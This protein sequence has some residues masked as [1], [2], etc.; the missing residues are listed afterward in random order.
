MD[1]T[2]NIFKLAHLFP[3]ALKKENFFFMLSL[4]GISRAFGGRDYSLSHNYEN[5]LKTWYLE[6]SEVRLIR[7]GDQLITEH[8]YQFE[9]P[10]RVQVDIPEHIP[11]EQAIEQ[12]MTMQPV[13]VNDGHVHFV[14]SSVPEPVSSPEPVLVEDGIAKEWPDVRADGAVLQLI[15][16]GDRLH[17]AII[18]P[19]AEP[20]EVPITLPDPDEMSIDEVINQLSRREC[21]LENDNVIRFKSEIDNETLIDSDNWSLTLVDSFVDRPW[22][23]PFTWGGHANIF[24]ETIEG[25]VPFLRW[26]HLM[27]SNYEPKIDERNLKQFDPSRIASQS[28]TWLRSKEMVQGM[29]DGIAYEKTRQDQGN[30]TANFNLRGNGAFGVKPK[31]VEGE[32]VTS[33]NCYTWAKDK[34]AKAGVHL[35]EKE[36]DKPIVVTPKSRISLDSLYSRERVS[37]W[38]YELGRY[39]IPGPPHHYDLTEQINTLLENRPWKLANNQD[40]QCGVAAVQS[41][42]GISHDGKELIFDLRGAAAPSDTGISHDG[43]EL[44]SVRRWPIGQSDTSISCD[45]KELAY[46][47]GVASIQNNT[48]ISCDGKEL[49][50]NLEG[51]EI[52]VQ[53][54]GE[55]IQQIDLTEM[56]QEQIHRD[57]LSKPFVMTYN[58]RSALGFYKGVDTCVIL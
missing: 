46:D 18:P 10:K 56:I 11:R 40:G 7:L 3:S 6:G 44:V 30:V 31:K 55:G 52:S 1:A 23:R 47:L 4:G 9:A 24:I 39:M 14:R 34:L 53:V 48:V 21:V 5:L 38:V 13:I 35:Y 20:I 51:A 26:K 33:H 57:V 54:V 8:V 45:G 12:L 28:V 36:S 42:T 19:F 58:L 32:E 15:R 27:S 22:R 49:A 37:V 29:L 17:Y 2:N 50:F 25:G 43:K 16:L 41:D